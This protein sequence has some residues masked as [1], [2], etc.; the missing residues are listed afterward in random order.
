MLYVSPVDHI[1]PERKGIALAYVRDTW[2]FPRSTEY[3][4]K[5]LGQYGGKGEKRSER[6]KPTPEE[7]KRV[8]QLNRE[9]KVRRL[10]KANFTED[11]YWVT[12]KYPKG[13]RPRV[14]SVKDDLSK[15][16]GKMR[17]W[18]KAAGSEL[19]FIYRMEI[20]SRGGVH[21]HM[22]V[23]RLEGGDTDLLIRKAWFPSKMNFEHLYDTG[24]YAALAAYIVKPPSVEAQKHMD[25]LPED[26]RHELI[27]YQPS[28][29]LIHPEPERKEFTHRTMRKILTEGP[30]PSPGCRIDSDSIRMGINPYTGMSYLHY[31]ETILSPPEK[32]K[33]LGSGSDKYKSCAGATK[34]KNGE[35]TTNYGTL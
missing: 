11:D 30:T 12:L 3:E 34:K 31:T 27:R 1:T 17:R 33:S 25:A 20:G 29:N 9:K 4:F 32:D 22:V 26:E 19:K 16:L 24:G 14:E 28:R 7:M 18:Y 21:I 15:F 23:N 2:R 10:I 6:S 13:A 8:N 35:R 5:F